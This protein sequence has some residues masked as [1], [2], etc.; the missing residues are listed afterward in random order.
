MARP[1][2]TPRRSLRAIVE[3]VAALS[4]RPPDTGLA[5]DE[6]QDFLFDGIA[7]VTR[8]A[9][10]L[11]PQTNPGVQTEIIR[12]ADVRAHLRQPG[13]AGADARPT[14]WRSI[15]TITS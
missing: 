5:L 4:G 13:V 15:R 7:N 12:R 11:A 10:H 1:T 6:H 3:R 8:M 9:A 2:R 14:R